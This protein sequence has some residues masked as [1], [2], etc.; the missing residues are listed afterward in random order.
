[1]PKPTYHLHVSLSHAATPRPGVRLKDARRLFQKA[2][3]NP[4]HS[5]HLGSTPRAHSGRLK[6]WASNNYC[7]HVGFGLVGRFGG[8]DSQSC[9]EPEAISRY[10]AGMWGFQR[11]QATDQATIH[12]V[13]FRNYGQSVGEA[14]ALGPSLNSRRPPGLAYT[15][16]ADDGT[17]Q[18]NADAD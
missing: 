18:R 15:N 7:A 6:D 4:V 14:Y 2:K 9:L 10:I 11:T 17:S 1:M 13:R 8:Y 16:T 3:F 12:V 5:G